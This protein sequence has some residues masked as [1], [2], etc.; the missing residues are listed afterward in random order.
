MRAHI[1][2]ARAFW[3][4]VIFLAFGSF[5]VVHAHAYSMGTATQM[6]PGY[7]PTLLGIV[8]L[9]LGAIS[10][11]RGVRAGRRTTIG[12]WPLTPLLF[13]LAGV[14]AF[15]ALITDWGLGPAVIALVLLGCHE[16]LLRRPLEVAV[17]GAALL[18]MATGIFIY[19]IQLPIDLWPSS[20]W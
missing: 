12:A 7:F 8:L 17:I 9:A 5:V 15:A 13:V 16:R 19:G 3:A 11:W 1:R 14:L 6:G 18:A 2:D 4:G 10:A 20:L